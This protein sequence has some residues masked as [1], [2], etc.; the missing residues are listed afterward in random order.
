VKILIFGGFL[1]AGKTTA[2]TQMMKYLAAG[3]PTAAAKTVL[4]ENE[5]GDAGI[6]DKTLGGT[7]MRVETLFS[8]CICCTMAGEM[9]ENIKYIS[10]KY[11]SEWL[12]LETTGMAYPGKIKENIREHFPELDCLLM[13]L[14]DAKRW[15][16]MQKIPELRQFSLDQLEDAD[17]ILINKRDLVS[18]EEM[19]E[20]DQSVREIGR[21]ASLYHVAAKD[22][23]EDAVW[24]QIFPE[25]LR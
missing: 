24:K 10:K 12:I 20:I 11:F 2:I 17:I 16:R 22:G 7:G 6:D 15:K 5:I 14:V 4:L 19:E 8:G 21:H 3:D 25:K 18:A 13:C 1:G 23:I 9:I